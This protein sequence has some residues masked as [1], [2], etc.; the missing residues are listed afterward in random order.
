MKA[1]LLGWNWIWHFIKWKLV[2]KYHSFL[3]NL[4]SIALI[5]SFILITKIHHFDENSSLQWKIIVSNLKSI[6]LLSF[7]LRGN[8]D[9]F[10]GLV[11]GWVFGRV[12]KIKIIDH[13]SPVETE[14]GT[15]LGNYFL[16]IYEQSKLYFLFLLIVTVPG[17]YIC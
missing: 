15:E 17:V 2:S 10:T 13:L 14:T 1:Y 12:G 9:S 3:D 5:D 7:A 8:Y 4:D 6:A 11:G 16:L